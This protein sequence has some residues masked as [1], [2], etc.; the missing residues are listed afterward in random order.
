MVELIK[1][2]DGHISLEYEM[3]DQELVKTLLFKIDQHYTPIQRQSYYVVKV[4]DV[5]L[6]HDQ[7]GMG[8]CLVSS[9]LE[10]DVILQ[11]L[12]DRLIS[13]DANSRG[14]NT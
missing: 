4:E 14:H 6:V 3:E 10:G 12:H 5:E 11:E 9:N 2:N 8:Q 13:A 7:D 1:L